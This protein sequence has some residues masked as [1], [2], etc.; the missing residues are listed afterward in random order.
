[1][2]ES[3]VEAAP[4]WAGNWDPRFANCSCYYRV[5]DLTSGTVIVNITESCNHAFGAAF[6]VT[7]AAGMDTLWITGTPWVR[8]NMEKGKGGGVG[9]VV[10]VQEEH[11]KEEE[12]DEE[13]DSYKN[14]GATVAINPDND[15]DN[16]NLFAGVSSNNSRRRRRQRRHNNILPSALNERQKWPRWSGPCAINNCTV[17]AF[18]S[19]DPLLQTWLVAEPAA[20]PVKNVFNNDVTHIGAPTTREAELRMRNSGLPPHQWIM[21]LEDGG[22]R[23]VFALSNSSDPSNPAGWTFLDQHTYILPTFNLSDVGS[24]PSV[25]FDPATG[26]YYVLTGGHVVRVL[27]SSDLINWSL[28]ANEGVILAPDKQDCMVAPAQYANFVP[29]GAA[30]AKIDACLSSPNPKGFGD[31]SDV[32]LI[33]AVINGTVTTLVQYGSS[34][35]ATF[36]FANLAYYPGPMFKFLDGLFV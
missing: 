3:I 13:E 14:N 35:Q 34:D 36:G 31:D 32:D 19:S 1:M 30:K 17:D 7:N 20:V 11:K 5:R 12:D 29:T 4:Q 8:Y 15:N 22:E 25:R 21:V 24:C 18:W 28:A 26:Y 27:R 9:K 16:D 10:N 23:T 2:F 6:V 33:E